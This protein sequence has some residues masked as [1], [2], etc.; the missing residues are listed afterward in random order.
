MIVLHFEESIKNKD[1]TFVS[2]LSVK[3]HISHDNKIHN[4]LNRAGMKI[5]SEMFRPCCWATSRMVS[6]L[7]LESSMISRKDI[8]F[9]SMATINSVVFTAIPSA[10]PSAQPSTRP[11]SRP[12]ERPAIRPSSRRSFS[13]SSSVYSLFSISLTS[14]YSLHTIGYST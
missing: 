7:A 8:F 6:S 11:S 3:C 4:L 9:F 5:H 14:S 13:A 12:S 2:P 10:I 1:E